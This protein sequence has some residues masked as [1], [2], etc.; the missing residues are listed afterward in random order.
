MDDQSLPG[1]EDEKSSEPKQSS[2]SQVDLPPLPTK[3]ST[4]PSPIA[5]RL[6]TALRSMYALSHKAARRL[7][8]THKVSIDGIGM[9]RWEAP[10][11]QGSMITINPSAPNL[12][13]NRALGAQLIF[14]DDAL[15]VISK[16][17]GLLSAPQRDSDDPSALQAA[18]RLCRGPRRPRVVH[19]LDKHTSGLLLFARTIPAARALQALLQER[20]I[21]RVYRCIVRGEVSENRGYLSSWLLR[22]AGRG[23]RGSRD[24]TFKYSPPHRRPEP[25]EQSQSTSTQNSSRPRPQG[26]WALTYFQVVSRQQG[27][28]ALEVE[29]FT[30]RTHQIRIHLSDLGHPIV[31]EW[32]YGPRVKR[33]PRLALH[34]ARLEFAHPFSQEQLCFEAPWPD[35]LSTHSGVPGTWLDGSASQAHSSPGSGHTQDRP[36]RSQA[37]SPKMKTPHKP[38]SAYGSKTSSKYAKAQRLGRKSRR[39]NKR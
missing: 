37:G 39:S 30:G 31:G 23:K 11:L 27:F 8:T 3:L 34:A 28:T 20:T 10:V 32:V 17:A 26:Q 18:S 13:K 2:S 22:D 38:S 16:P 12:S 9:D 7:I 6:D 21:K 14:Q 35:E 25:E 5:G 15:V 29:L 36:R 33:E 4:L 19:R 1:D 24:R